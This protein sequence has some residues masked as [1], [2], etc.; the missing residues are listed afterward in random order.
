MSRISSARLVCAALILSCPAFAYADALT[1]DLP[2]AHARARRQAPD[3]IAA[4]ARIAQARAAGIGARIRFEENVDI[5]AGGGVRSGNPLTVAA[6]VRIGQSLELG[7]RS[8]RIAVADAGEREAL[9][10]TEAALRELDLVVSLAFNAARHAD[11]E[12]EL[13]TLAEALTS[14]SV[15]AAEKRHR[16]GELSDLDLDLAKIARGRARA[17]LASARS[18]RAEAI[19][20]LAALIGAAPGDTI[21]LRG[22][23]TTPPPSLESLRAALAK[24]PDIR[25]LDA[26]AGVARAQ[27]DLA[28]V[29][30]WPALGVWFGYVRDEMDNIF[31]GG[32]SVTLPLWNREQGNLAAARAKESAAQHRR[33]ALLASAARQLEDAYTSYV[34]QRESLDTMAREILPAIDDA[35]KLVEKGIDAGQVGVSELIVVRQEVTTA[36]REYIDR[37]LD[38][39]NSVAQV[40][41]L[42]GVT[43]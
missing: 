15:T 36:R 7:R 1:I 33:A 22:D 40:R 30:R 38:L 41:Y 4:H 17:T 43:P 39:A 5:T 12:V 2:T 20:K 6:D 13:A 27:R 29:K 42:A 11:L 19:G 34:H 35:Q 31:F 16:A 21:T 23:L 10:E 32:L 26:E 9:A 25:A 18:D 37:Q 24:R 14:R 28:R 8:A 3:A